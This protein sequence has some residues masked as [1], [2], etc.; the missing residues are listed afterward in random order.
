MKAR[1]GRFLLIL[2]AGLAAM[3]FVVVYL[4]MSRGSQP[5]QDNNT[6]SVPDAPVMKTIVVAK[7]DIAA[8][9]LLDE[10]NLGLLE[11]EASTVPVD[12]VTDPSTLYRKMASKAVQ[13]NHAILASDVT[14]VGFSNLLA[15]GER[16]FSLPVTARNTFA[17]SLTEGDRVDVLWST[18]FKVNVPYLG[19]DGKIKFEKDVYT[20][21]KTLLQ[22][23][24]IL[25]V[26]SLRAVLPEKP[27]ADGTPQ[28]ANVSAPQVSLSSLYTDDAPYSAVLLLAVNDQA[29]EV[30]KY[31]MENG[32]NIDL[33][34]RSSAALKNADGTPV[35]D[36]AGKE[37]KGD[38]DVEKTN[39]VTIDELIKSYGLTTP[40]AQWGPAATP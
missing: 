18:A 31:A 29:A 20:S 23:V 17:D 33:T 36:A 9:T 4:V 13:A 25:R 39:G 1:G 40:P 3:A 6:A 19:E 24:K 38:H 32:G 8:Y 14:A 27:A 15:K 11:V 34:L 35:K 5:T 2:G 28:A 16:A 26:T 37:V 7:G 30:L 21:T 10:S 22:D 12:A